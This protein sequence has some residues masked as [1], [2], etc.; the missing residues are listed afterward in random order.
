MKE[1]LS[2]SK[3]EEPLPLIFDS[4]HSGQVYPDDFGHACT[5]EDLES[6]EDKFVDELFAGAPT[7][8]GALLSACFPRCYIDANRAADDIDP[9]LLEDGEWP[10]GEIT[11]TARSDAG[12]GLIRRLVKPG[13][14]VYNRFLS[15]EEIVQRIEKYYRPYHK[16]LEE[17]IEEAHY[18]FGQVWHINCHS[19]P[20]ASA[21][22]KRPIGLVG[23]QPQIPDFV[24]GNRDGATS[25]LEFTREVKAFLKDLGYVV[26]LNDPFKGVELIRR[27]ADPSRGRHSLQLEINKALY[28]N[29]NTNEKNANYNAL[30]ADIGKFVAFCADYVKSNLTSLAA[31]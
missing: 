22:P 8:G 31:D 6:T 18:N 21:Q 3:P 1:I 10:L 12:I 26:S 15:A 27:H 24:L 13:T 2:V 14:P 5:K 28:L 29:E 20:S 23:G 11:P 7:H 17:L 16:A 9:K 19:M 4:P 25:S 30:K